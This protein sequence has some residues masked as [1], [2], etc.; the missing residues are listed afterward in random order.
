MSAEPAFGTTTGGRPVHART[1]Q[2][3]PAMLRLNPKLLHADLQAADARSAKTFEDIERVKTDV[4]TA[5]DRL[6]ITT[7]GGIKEILDA[8]N[9]LAVQPRPGAS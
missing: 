8:V 6:D 7:E 4:S 2:Y 1:R 3:L 5:L 9:R